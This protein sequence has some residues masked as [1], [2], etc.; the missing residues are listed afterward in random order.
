M[1]SNWDF[2]SIQ[3]YITDEIQEH[4]SLDYKAVGALAKSSGKRDEITKDVS[5]MA[6][7]AGGIIIYGIAEY[8]DPGKRHLPERID[9]VDQRLF[10]K[11]WLE[12]IIHSI[13]PR[14]DGILIHPI[15]VPG[16]PD[17]VIYVVEVPQS[18]TA[19]QAADRRYY[20]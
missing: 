6:N 2:A 16:R 19:H 3:R 11:E 17:H 14:I 8:A 1:T 20:K 12:Q 4:N 15:P 7:A 18:T 5:A 10:S 9:P 13:R